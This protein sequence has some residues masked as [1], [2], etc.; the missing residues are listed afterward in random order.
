M[1]GE[2]PVKDA[3]GE[4]LGDSIYATFNL[5]EAVLLAKQHKFQTS[6]MM[7]VSSQLPKLPLIAYV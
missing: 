7:Y 1:E 2:D 4:P 6:L 5:Q 3:S